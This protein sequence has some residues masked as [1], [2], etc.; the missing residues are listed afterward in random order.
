MHWNGASGLWDTPQTVET[1]RRAVASL[2]C[3]AVLKTSRKQPR[4]LP[5]EKRVNETYQREKRARAFAQ[6]IR[7]TWNGPLS[8]DE[9]RQLGQMIRDEV[10]GAP[11]RDSLEAIIIGALREK[12][13][14]P[15]ELGLRWS[16]DG[17]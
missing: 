16:L 2:P 9:K 10:D 11:D 15:D 4:R 13:I 6:S 12:H 14:D 3:S 1:Q 7:E 8:G 5:G 17:G